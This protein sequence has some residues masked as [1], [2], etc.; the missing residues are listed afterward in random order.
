[1]LDIS[2][3]INQAFAPILLAKTT[4]YEDQ[5]ILSSQELLDISE[6]IS[7]DFAPKS[8]NNKQ[9]LVLLPIDPDHVHAYWNL[10]DEKTSDTKNNALIEQLTLRVY[11]ET[12]TSN[13]ITEHKPWFDFAIDGNRSQQSFFLPNRTQDNAYCA[14]IGERDQDNS[15]NAFASSNTTYVPLGKVMTNP[16]K[17][18]PLAFKATP[19][20][21]KINLGAPLFWKNTASGQ[22][23]N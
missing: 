12:D 10:S 20:P 19:E 3:E 23:H 18:S 2:L 8:S 16:I 14:I 22:R 4:T 5:Y 15:L 21:I 6:E 11:S 17:E 13:D 7:I 1:M 9:E